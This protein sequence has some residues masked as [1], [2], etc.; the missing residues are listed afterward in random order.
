MPVLLIG[1]LGINPVLSQPQSAR[2]GASS[3]RQFS[4][5][6]GPELAR[7]KRLSTCLR[8]A[9]SYAGG[10]DVYVRHFY[11]IE[12]KVKAGATQTD[13]ANH[14][15]QVENALNS[16]LKYDIFS[17]Y[18]NSIG[19]KTTYL[20]VLEEK[21]KPHTE[22]LS[23]IPAACAVDFSIN[24]N[25][26]LTS[27][28]PCSEYRATPA[29]T[30]E[31]RRIL[32]SVRSLPPG[33]EDNL[34]LHL[35]IENTPARTMLLSCEHNISFTNYMNSIQAKVKTLWH[36]AKSKQSKSTKVEWFVNRSGQ[37]S[38]IK[39]ISSSGS[40]EHDQEAIRVL[41]EAKIFPLVPDGSP[42]KIG[43]SFD[44]DYNVWK[45]NQDGTKQ[46]I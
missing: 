24:R 23:T 17:L 5:A 12:K 26:Q 2:S 34:P 8:I 13:I 18:D 1:A 10:I 44:F 46:K 9:N 3:A 15:S 31:L 42:D 19:P 22:K 39:V 38:D 28:N 27:I 20:K 25:G 35:E 21:L 16:K 32:Q 6:P 30:S 33:P 45:K 37:I 29:S 40:A 4:F 36:P 11:E 41:K 7:R 14:L 43:I